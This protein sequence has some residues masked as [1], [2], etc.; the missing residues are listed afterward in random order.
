MATYSRQIRDALLSAAAA[1]GHLSSVQ[2]H[3]I[4]PA[5]PSGISASMVLTKQFT[6]PARSGLQVTSMAL[7]FLMRLST[8]AMSEP[9]SDIDLRLLDAQDALILAYHGDLDLGYTGACVDVL[10]MSGIPLGSDSGYTTV[11]KFLMRSF[12]LTIPVIIDD[13]WG[14]TR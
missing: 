14:Q 10:G 3:D 12:D 9:R 8:N 6:V 1:T 2:G 13:V 4:V 7:V 11:D 5:A